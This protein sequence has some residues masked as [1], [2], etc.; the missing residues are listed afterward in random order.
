[1]TLL[2]VREEIDDDCV[3]G[4]DGITKGIGDETEEKEKPARPKGGEDD[5]E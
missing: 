3:I 4:R 2:T 5:D 1:M